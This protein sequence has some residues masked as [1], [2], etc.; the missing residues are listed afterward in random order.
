MK[1]ITASIFVLLFCVVLSVT[2]CAMESQG[3]VTLA[4]FI[5]RW[6]SYEMTFSDSKRGFMEIEISQSTITSQ[7]IFSNNQQSD[8]L[9]TLLISSSEFY[10]QTA[11]IV[12][13]NSLGK[14]RGFNPTFTTSAKN[15]F[16]E[17]VNNITYTRQ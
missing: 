8:P 17:R 13:I 12:L 7:R 2:S 15:I 6:K 5:G 4:D 11:N 1:K 10:G 14:K 9:Q 16:I 3:N